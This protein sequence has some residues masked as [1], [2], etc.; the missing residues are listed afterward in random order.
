MLWNTK[1]TGFCL[2]GLIAVES[3]TYIAACRTV[4]SQYTMPLLVAICQRPQVKTRKQ[5]KALIK[6]VQ[7]AYMAWPRRLLYGIMNLAA[8][9]AAS[10]VSPARKKTKMPVGVEA[11]AMLEKEA[12]L[13]KY[14][15]TT[16]WK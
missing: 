2:T 16:A 11:S 8:V 13:C 14:L 7:G 6:S 9:L 1:L 5:E 12:P 10:F 3:H 4:C 15:M